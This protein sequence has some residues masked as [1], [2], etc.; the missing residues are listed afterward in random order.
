[1]AV[2]PNTS[3]L[4]SDYRLS[5]SP[6]TLEYRK[7]TELLSHP[8]CSECKKAFFP[9]PSEVN[10]TSLN[11]LSLKCNSLIERKSLIMKFY[12]LSWKEKKTK[13]KNHNYVLSVIFHCINWIIFS[14]FFFW[15]IYL[16]MCIH[17]TS[18]ST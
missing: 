14:S 17:F 11:V 7:E 8:D 9:S 3:L 1:M 2:P 5:F 12:L 16:Y 15:C 13:N 6:E 10:D 18:T 4:S